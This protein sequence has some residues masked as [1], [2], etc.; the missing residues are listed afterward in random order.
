MSECLVEQAAA[1]AQCCAV[2][3]CGLC[4]ASSRPLEAESITLWPERPRVAPDREHVKDQRVHAVDNPS[5]QPFWPDAEV[6]N[7]SSVV[8]FPGGG[9]SRLALKHEGI[10]IARWF[11]ARG[12]AAF[13]VKYR[14]QEYGYPAP[15]LD[16]QRALRLVR[17]HGQAWQLDAH[18]I[19][20]VGFSAGGH[21][22][23]SLVLMQSVPA[24]LNPVVDPYVA[25]SARPDF[26]LLG[27]PVISMEG[28]DA[29]VG[30][31]RALLG[32]EPAVELLHACSLKHHVSPAV[33]P[34]FMFHGVADG[35]VPVVHS[36]EF[37][38]AL[39]KYNKQSELHI[40]QSTIHGVG[41][42]QGHGSI[43]GWPQALEPWLR[44]N[45]LIK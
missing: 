2:D 45:Q 44:Q 10:D 41:M 40:Y 19:G 5:M 17:A 38:A 13:V 32:E 16:A 33:P 18:K 15:L 9:Y 20:A 14:L 42:I 23:A 7:G 30:S 39:Q 25:I 1:S 12:V 4:L 31:R 27:Y 21:L 22:A 24:A 28:A 37:F 26:A 36:L 35:A 43:S 3:G 11:C 34:V 6:A 8:I 29:H